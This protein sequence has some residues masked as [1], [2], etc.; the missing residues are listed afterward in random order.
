M[1]GPNSERRSRKRIPA[2]LPV[3]IKA[4][5]QSLTGQTRD[6]S[7]SG[8]FLYSGAELAEGSELELVLV[9]PS[10][11]TGGQKQWVCCQA[12]VIRAEKAE[13]D[14]GFGIAATIRHIAPLPEIGS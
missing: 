8:I 12:T 4:A 11:L 13:G 1:M 5:G 2:S 3:S 6:L 9:L 14:A 10:E 7:T